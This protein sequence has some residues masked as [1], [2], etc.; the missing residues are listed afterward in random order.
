MPR[1]RGL[2]SANIVGLLNHIH[3]LGVIDDKG[4]RRGALKMLLKQGLVRQVWI[5]NYTLTEEG[6]R[7]R[8]LSPG[9]VPVNQVAK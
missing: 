4:L 7:V 9:D 3:S 1:G 8:K 6:Q 2:G 5:G